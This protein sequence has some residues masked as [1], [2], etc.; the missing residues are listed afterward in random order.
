[1]T[2][3][4]QLSEDAILIGDQNRL[5]TFGEMDVIADFRFQLLE[6]HSTHIS[7]ISPA[8][9]LCQEPYR[10]GRTSTSNSSSESGQFAI[11]SWALIV[12]T[13]RLCSARKDG[14]VSAG[15]TKEVEPL[16][17]W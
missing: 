1:M 14:M 15:I 10:P 4:N 12:Q 9:I 8:A 17:I 16:A 7:K 6:G 13:I 2:R 11:S 5:A 3:R